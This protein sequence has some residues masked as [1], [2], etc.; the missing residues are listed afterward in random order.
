VG[1]QEPSPDTFYQGANSHVYATTP[2]LPVILALVQVSHIQCTGGA[3]KP[4]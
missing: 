3:L 4:R 2:S 1:K